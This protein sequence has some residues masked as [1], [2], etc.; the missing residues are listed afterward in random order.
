MVRGSRGDQAEEEAE[1]E[2]PVKKRATRN[3][4]AADQIK[5]KHRVKE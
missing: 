1:V 2:K 3:K 4:P 5:T